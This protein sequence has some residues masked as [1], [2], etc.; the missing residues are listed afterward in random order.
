MTYRLGFDIGG[1]FTDLILVDAETGTVHREKVPT[2]PEDFADGAIS[3]IEQLCEAAGATYE[4]VGHLSHGTT[5]ATNALIERDGAETGVLATDGFRDVLA[6]GREK[7]SEIYDLAPTKTPTFAERRHRRGVSERVSVDGEVLEPLDEAEVAETV[8]ELEADGVESVAVSLLH[9][10][11]FGEHEQ[12]IADIVREHTDLDVSLSSN[13]MSELNEYERTLSTT[14]D[15]YVNPLIS[16]YLER[17]TGRLASL[18]V[19]ETLHLMQANGGVITPE[20]VAGRRLRLINSGPAAGA[21]G[22]KRLA[23]AAGYDD[24]ITLDMGGTSTDTC[25]VRDGTL[26]TTTQGEIEG[27]PLLFPQIDIRS[28]GTGGG[29]IAHVD[30]AG[31]LKV[32][33][34]S[35]GATPGP[36]CYGRGG[37][38]PTVTDAAVAL[39]YLNPENFL[40][41]EMEL[42]VNAAEDTLDSLAE[43]LGLD[44]VELA[45]GIH[46]I[47]A[48]SMVGGIRKVTVER[49]Y[50]P[51]EF[52]LVCYGGAGPLFADVLASKLGIGRALVPPTSGIL[53]AFGLVTADRRFD[54]SRSQ[55]FML[56]KDRLDEVN[57]IYEDLE[58]EAAEAGSNVEFGR[59]VDLRYHGQSFDLTIDVPGGDLDESDLATVLNDFRESYQT[60]YGT[61]SDDPI[62]AVTWR[63]EAVDPID[64][65][66]PSISGAENSVDD[67]ATGARQAYTGNGFEEFDIYDRYSL[68]SGVSVTGP[69]I[70]EEAESTTVVGVDTTFHVDDTGN[71]VLDLF[72]EP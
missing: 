41:G 27:I 61:A 59:A 3:G 72:G 68:P 62:E 2:T 69:A 15:A 71:L 36:A 57:A 66:D 52:T 37:T 5:V 1:T 35:A 9:A 56:S 14:I 29:S 16:D 53:S 8:R 7:R 46:E 10:Y 26:E 38:D 39:G 19:D 17:L 42:D 70:V 11:R 24:V 6:I 63:L 25:V 65:V 33:P 50:D 31:V 20:T 21:L 45:A 55:P 28:I 12:A 67:A 47:T 4:D 51:R 49:G 32:G 18:G 54:F 13:V 64:D 22:A 23:S 34:E 43:T 30:K 40:G 44:L 60:V 58:A 48:T